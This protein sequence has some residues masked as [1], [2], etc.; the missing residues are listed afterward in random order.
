MS[1]LPAWLTLLLE[2]TAQIASPSLGGQLL[3]HFPSA[4][5]SALFPSWR[6]AQPRSLCPPLKPQILDGRDRGD[7]VRGCVSIAPSSAWHRVGVLKSRWSNQWVGG[8]LP[9][10]LEAA[11]VMQV[12]EEAG[13]AAAG[14]KARSETSWS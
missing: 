9:A 10:G 12:E 6:W 4:T 7:L 5:S 8:R 3:R 13:V 1:P 14:E 2:A 11:A